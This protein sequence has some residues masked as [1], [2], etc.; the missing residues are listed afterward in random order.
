MR[1]SRD[2]N[3]KRIKEIASQISEL[4]REL[5]ES[6][7][8][9]D[10][11]YSS[12]SCNYQPKTESEQFVFKQ[13]ERNRPLEI[14]DRVVIL[15]VYKGN[16]EKKERIVETSGSRF[17]L[18]ATGKL[19]GEST[20][21]QNEPEVNRL[22]WRRKKLTGPR[23]SPAKKSGKSRR[24]KPGSTSNKSKFKGAI[25]ELNGHMFEVHSESIKSSQFQRTVDELSMYMARKYEHGGDVSMTLS[26]MEEFDFNKVEPQA[27]STVRDAVDQR[28]FEKQMD[29]HVKLLAR[30][31]ENKRA[32]Y[33]IIWGQCSETMQ[34]KLKTMTD[35]KQM[36]SDRD[37]LL[38]L[39]T[40]QGVIFHFET[41]N[42]PHRALHDAFA[43]FYALKQHR[44]QSNSE[45][46]TKFKNQV[47]VIDHYGGSIGNHN[48]LVVDEVCRTHN[49]SSVDPTSTEYIDAIPDANNHYL[50]YCFLRFADNHRYSKLLDMLAN[51]L[52]LGNDQYPADVTKAYGMLVNYKRDSKRNS[53]EKEKEQQDEADQNLVSDSDD[54]QENEEEE[55]TFLKKNN[56]NSKKILASTQ[57]LLH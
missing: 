43:T 56:S 10:S 29:L 55:M 13:K 33:M 42:Y 30:Y 25:A 54:N 12:S 5:N 3:K 57:S 23:V 50:A 48:R 52:M 24:K 49:V 26:D 19:K 51:Q 2:S 8:I 15:N 27:P 20:E 37:S 17:C 47:N 4:S 9:E 46:L 35:F 44:H 18:G 7:L 53:S 6:L 1:S 28:I 40:I 36:H 21:S 34:A 38:L 39:T 11:S 32:L 16:K 31:E 45:Y 14:N 41:Q 22:K